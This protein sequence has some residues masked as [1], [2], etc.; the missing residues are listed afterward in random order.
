MTTYI[1]ADGESLF[2]RELGQGRPVL[3]LSG[4]G[5]KS[6]HWLPYILPYHRQFRFIIPE[7]RGFGRSQTCQIPGDLD[8]ISS[9]W[10]DV[11]S[12]LAQLP[13]QDY[14]VMA[15]SMGATVAMHGMHY[16]NFGQ[17]INAYLHIDQ[18]PKI[19]TDQHWSYGL[20]AQQHTLFKQRLAA[21]ADCLTRATLHA[22]TLM[23]LQHPI[24]AQ[25]LQRWFEL[26]QWQ[27]N[28]RIAPFLFKLA[29]KRDQLQQYLL[30]LQRLDYMA[31]YV[32][33][34]LEHNEDYR[35]ALCQLDCPTTFFI[36]QQS[37]LYPYQGQ[38]NIAQQLQQAQSIIFEKSG[39]TPLLSEPL[40]F[41]LELR[42]FLQTPAG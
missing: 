4:L 17:Q 41:A 29:Q 11:T 2:V 36:G 35:E 22:K 21:L 15:Y 1:M 25:L 20:F 28:N 14:T 40:K 32:N 38:L 5:M 37:N 39:H 3:I 7:W 9:H 31:W 16:A 23:Q 19:V 8:A 34:Y 27:G 42:K 26:V 33:T 12:L 6:Y 10:R 18:S 13:T 24:K 30:P